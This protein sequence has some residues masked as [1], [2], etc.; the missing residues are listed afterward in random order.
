MLDPTISILNFQS[1]HNTCG[2][3]QELNINAGKINAVAE[4]GISR[5]IVP[6][7]CGLATCP[8]KYL[9]FISKPDKGGLF[10]GLHGRI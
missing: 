6:C 3:S 2:V 9:N 10:T 8:Y 5:H 4:V 1:P 7:C